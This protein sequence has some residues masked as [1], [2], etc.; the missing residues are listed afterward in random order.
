MIIFISIFDRFLGIVKFAEARD[1]KM[2]L[3]VNGFGNNG[4]KIRRTRLEPPLNET[5]K[6]SDLRA[7]VSDIINRTPDSFILMHCGVRLI[8]FH[9]HIDIIVFIFY[10]FYAF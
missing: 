7:R 10:R 8:R 1:L 2:F 9:I 5:A 4:P 3:L 6:V